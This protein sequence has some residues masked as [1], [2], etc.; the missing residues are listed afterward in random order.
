MDYVPSNE[1][2]GFFVLLAI[3]IK[4]IFIIPFFFKI[5]N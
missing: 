3:N 2:Y 5:A 1:I 4:L